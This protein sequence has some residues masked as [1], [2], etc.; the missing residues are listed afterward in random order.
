[1]SATDYP[2]KPQWLMQ[3]SRFNAARLDDLGTFVAGVCLI[4]CVGLPL[5]L[6]LA[7]T[8]AHLVPGDE[9]IHRL[10]S[11]LVVGAGVPSFWIG[12]RKH[13]KKRVL[14]I[15]L[16]GMGIVLTALFIGDRFGS[17]SREVAIT[18]F[19]SSFLVTAH[20]LNKTFCKRCSRCAH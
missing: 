20:L 12:F 2:S 10:L 19:G 17:H 7:P 4:H 5:F 3:I 9:L 15:G 8:L 13:R 14:S 11:F 1:M 18:M 16:A 6:S